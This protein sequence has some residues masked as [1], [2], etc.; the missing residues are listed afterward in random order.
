[1]KVVQLGCGITGLVCAE[2]LT[3]NQNVDEVVLADAWTDAA[4]SMMKRVN[5]EKLS[6]KKA[7]ARDLESVKSLLKGADLVVSAIPWELNLPVLRTAADCGVDYVDFSMSMDSTEE[8]NKISALCESK[9]TTALTSMGADP[10]ISDVMAVYAAKK[11]DS[12]ETARVMDGDT[13]S[14]EGY[15]WFTLWSPLEM[16]EEMTIPAAVY[17]DGEIKYL[18]PLHER[19]LYEF[20]EP[21]GVQPVYN[22]THEETWL[23]P[24]NVKGIKY[25]DFRIAID[26]N[27]AKTANTLRKIGMHGMKPVNVK[28][29]TVR[30]IDVV[31]S[32]MPRPVE[33][34]G[35]VKGHAAIVVEITGTSGGKKMMSKAWASMSHEKAYELFNSNATGYFVGTGGATGAELIIDGVFKKKG[36]FAPEQL[37]SDEF[38]KRLKTKH[39]E[40]KGEIKPL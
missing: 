9:G 8:F 18:P 33:L 37:P 40:V 35:K 2:H 10:G 23:I 1:M 19:Q 13:G 20:P 12:P 24:Q 36:L 5:S 38:L 14:A 39:L 4:E 30:P 29:Q 22:T 31:T 34:I 3:K 27:T 17:K 6:V 21:I 15:D 16:L 32:L 11:L 26:D 7:D 25:A 28:G